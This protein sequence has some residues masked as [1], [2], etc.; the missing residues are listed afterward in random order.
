M[1]N[2][3]VGKQLGISAL[4][5]KSHLHRLH[6]IFQV[7]D[8]IALTERMRRFGHV[9]Y[10]TMEDPELGIGRATR[11][12]LR[13]LIG[14]RRGLSA[15]EIGS[16]VFS[17]PDTVKTHLRRLGLC[18]GTPGGRMK[19]VNEAYRRGFFQPPEAPKPWEF[20][21]PRASSWGRR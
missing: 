19:L 16:R 18:W 3:Q 1:T 12:E 11:S 7:T 20:Q 10:P 5:V 6:R 17:S 8:R 13:I 9:P 4:T 15:E 14:V 2:Q 21:H